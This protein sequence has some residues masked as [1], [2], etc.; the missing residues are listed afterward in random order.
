MKLP[1]RTFLR[2]L[3]YGILFISLLFF[4]GEFISLAIPFI[5]YLFLAWIVSARTEA[6]EIHQT[7]DRER[8]SEGETVNARL[9]IENTGE[10]DCLFKARYAAPDGLRLAGD[11]ADFIAILKRGERLDQDTSLEC[12]RGVHT[13]GDLTLFVSEPLGLHFKPLVHRSSQKII[14]LPVPRPIRTI[15]IRPRRTKVFAGTIPANLGGTGNEFFAVRRYMDGDPLHHIN[16]RASA[17]HD[18]SFFI[19]QYQQER[20]ADVAVLVDARS[21]ANLLDSS[22][23]LLD[24]SVQAAATVANSLLANGNRVGVLSFGSHL[25]WTFPGYGKVQ[26]ERIL[27]ALARVSPGESQIFDELKNLPVRLFPAK[28]QLILISPL[29]NG[30]YDMLTQLRARGYQLLVISPEDKQEMGDLP[31]STTAHLATRLA[32]LERTLLLRKLGQAGILVLPWDVRQPVEEIL[33]RYYRTPTL[34]LR[35]GG[36][37]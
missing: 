18:A 35:S 14:A 1:S 22:I 37:P 20:V 13:L 6:V 9:S 31:E 2:L 23:S 36:R 15:M 24:Y 21:R 32:A 26:R 4:S 29:L 16:W 7:I 17:R 27:R 8:V 3:I 10:V 34:W 19:N 28:S 5:L 11:S 25:Q 33:N 30:D 12:N